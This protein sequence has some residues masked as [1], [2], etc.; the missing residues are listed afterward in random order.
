MVGSR[1]PIR[2]CRTE[3]EWDRLVKDN[4]ELAQFANR[5]LQLAQLRLAAA[6]KPNGLAGTC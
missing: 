5:R 1:I 2:I 3:A 4:Q 6:G